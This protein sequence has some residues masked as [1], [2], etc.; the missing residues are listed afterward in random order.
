MKQLYEKTELGLLSRCGDKPLTQ[1]HPHAALENF[2][3]FCLR[4]EYTCV[5]RFRERMMKK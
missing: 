1:T 4:C 5:I 2:P 3:P